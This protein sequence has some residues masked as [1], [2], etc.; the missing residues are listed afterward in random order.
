MRFWAAMGQ[1]ASFL[2]G[3][4]L[5]GAYVGFGPVSAPNLPL[6]FASVALMVLASFWIRWAVTERN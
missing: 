2:S 3:I 5:S 6:V 1:I 4:F